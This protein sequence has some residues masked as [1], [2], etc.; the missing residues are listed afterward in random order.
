MPENPPYFW[1]GLSGV[2]HFMKK[3][4]GPDAAISSSE[5]GEVKVPS[6]ID[7]PAREVG[8]LVHVRFTCKRDVRLK[9]LGGRDG[10]GS[11][12]RP[13]QCQ[14]TPPMSPGGVRCLRGSDQIA[15]KSGPWSQS[16]SAAS[17]G[18]VRIHRYHF[19]L[20]C[21]GRCFN[22]HSLFLALSSPCARCFS[23]TGRYPGKP[24]PF[25]S[26]T[27]SSCSGVWS[28][29]RQQEMKGENAISKQHRPEDGALRGA[30][31]GGVAGYPQK[32]SRGRFSHV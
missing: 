21:S 23:T 4:R 27:P 25:E 8:R 10:G 31:R 20:S 22:C 11:V 29:R 15:L 2:G 16:P 18:P 7:A 1:G 5:G 32:G 17:A 26:V 24:S 13:V 14:K 30:P 9:N 6:A 12:L 19:T 3:D 28:N